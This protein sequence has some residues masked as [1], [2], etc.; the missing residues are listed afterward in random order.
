MNPKRTFEKVIVHCSDTPDDS[1]AAFDVHD[2]RRWHKRRGWSDCGYHWVV[3]R[4]GEVQAGRPEKLIGAHCRGQN[5]SSIGVCLVGREAFEK[6]QLE[7]L[8]DIFFRIKKDYKI[9]IPDW[10]CHNEFTTGKTCPGFSGGFLRAWL[11]QSIE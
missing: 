10:Y 7:R 2:I 9:D 1:P 4:A 5:Y 6:V 11:L 8:R 3:T